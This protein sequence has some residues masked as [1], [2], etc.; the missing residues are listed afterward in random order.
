MKELREKH[1][2]K[3]KEDQD[4][5]HKKRFTEQKQKD[6]IEKF[7]QSVQSDE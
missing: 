1:L 4:R 5:E 2:Q 6:T 7:F 3:L